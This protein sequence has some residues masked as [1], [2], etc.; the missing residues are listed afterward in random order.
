MDWR[1]GRVFVH[2]SEENFRGRPVKAEVVGVNG[3]GFV[4]NG[5][6]AMAE[7]Q[8]IIYNVYTLQFNYAVLQFQAAHRWYWTADY[9]GAWEADL[10]G[11]QLIPRRASLGS[12]VRSAEDCTWSR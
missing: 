5:K 3:K 6:L 10:D 9:R 4:G 1:Q 7:E 11:P 8:V 2:L 12:P